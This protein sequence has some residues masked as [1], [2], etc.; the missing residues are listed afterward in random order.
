MKVHRVPSTI[1]LKET[2]GIREYAITLEN[3]TVSEVLHQYVEQSAYK[4]LVT[5]L[6][7]ALSPHYEEIR[8]I[9]DGIS[10]EEGIHVIKLIDSIKDAAE[11]M[12]GIK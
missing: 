11:K 12:Y 3:K 6:E 1:F 2:F 10:K 7:D 5:F 9:G 4:E 8:R